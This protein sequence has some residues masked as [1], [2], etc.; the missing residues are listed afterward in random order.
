MEKDGDSMEKNNELIRLGEHREWQ[1][2][3][4]FLDWGEDGKLCYGIDNSG[5]LC[6]PV[7]V[8]VKLP[9]AEES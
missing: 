4:P 8:N 9:N 5:K 7:K 6:L 2:K 1:T 3:L